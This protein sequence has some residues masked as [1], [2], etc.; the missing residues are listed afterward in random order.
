MEQKIKKKKVVNFPS[1]VVLRVTEIEHK[2]L[3]EFAKKQNT[4]ITKLLRVF[5]Q[6]LTQDV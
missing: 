1:R 3:K 6:D 5:I 2:K 4:T